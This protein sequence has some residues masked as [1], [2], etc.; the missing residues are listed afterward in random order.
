MTPLAAV[1][2]KVLFCYIA[3]VETTFS[4]FYG[5]AFPWWKSEFGRQILIYAAA[6]AAIMD[7]TVLRMFWPPPW[8]LFFACYVVFAGVITWRLAI[9]FRMWLA[10]RAE[11]TPKHRNPL[12]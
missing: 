6:V 12:P 8:W 5:F 7:L 10:G 9:L 2:F 11:R 3:L 1:L 4:V